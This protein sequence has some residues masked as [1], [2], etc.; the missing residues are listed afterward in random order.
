MAGG[1]VTTPIQPYNLNSQNTT[2]SF[3]AGGLPSVYGY[4]NGTTITAW[5]GNNVILVPNGSGNTWLW[6]YCG[7]TNAGGITQVLV[8]QV[9][10]GQIL[11]A[12]TT[13]T[14]AVNESGWLGP[15]SPSI[16]N[17]DNVSVVPTGIAQGPTIA[18]WPTAALGCYAV[19]FTLTTQLLVRAYTMSSVQP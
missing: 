5:G 15:F 10:A 9:L 19:A 6:Y 18:S 1:L 14:I 16:Y 4:D 11:P 7:P 17:I 13:R 8:G 2:G 12:S 3:F